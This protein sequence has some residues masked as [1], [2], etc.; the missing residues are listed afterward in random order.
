[1]ASNYASVVRALLLVLP[2][3]ACSATPSPPPASKRPS[4]HAP[5][6][7]AQ[8]SAYPGRRASGAD[9]RLPAAPPTGPAISGITLQDPTG[10]PP[11]HAWP[12]PAGPEIPSG[13]NWSKPVKLTHKPDGGFRPQVAV[14]P[15]G[16][17]HVIYY[18]RTDHGDIVRNRNSID[19][20]HWTDPV[21]VS[22]PRG[23]NWGPDI[24]ARADGSVVVVYDHEESDRS[25]RGWLTVWRDGRWGT[26][27]PFTPKNGGEV[28]SVHVADGPGE[29]LVAVWIEKALDPKAHFRAWWSWYRDGQWSMP[30]AFTDGKTLDTWHTNVERR[31]D[32]SV[33]AGFDVGIGGGE[34]TP[35]TVEGRGG[36]FGTPEEMAVGAQRGERPNFAF[37]PD[38]TDEVTW[39]HKV[40]GRPV[41]V[42]VRRGRP[43]HW[44]PIEEPSKGYGGYH[45]DPDIAVNAAGVRCVVWGWDAG[46]TAELVYSIDRGQGWSP[47]RR[48]ADIGWGKPG[49]PSLVTDAEGRFD[50][51]W[52]QGVR[53]YSD[54]YFA[55]LEVK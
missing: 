6:Q 40:Q 16:L 32:G 25:R 17:I 24:V 30:V 11:F 33:L 49:L 36:R 9:E 42:Y 39:F 45:F 7:P 21:T 15:D 19:G 38:G 5:V 14:G 55:R 26:P 44:G 18:D 46:K 52:T 8:P 22:Q 48:V 4:G 51:V 13:G 10:F 34:S 47:P 31:P 12:A 27:E 35:Y 54:V 3:A 1:M 53:G 23:T 28:G 2:F 41:H 29:Q 20:I 43:G 37:G 50:V